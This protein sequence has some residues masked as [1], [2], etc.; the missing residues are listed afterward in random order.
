MPN[1]VLVSLADLE[2]AMT[3]KK[4]RQLLGIAGDAS[5]PADRVQM[6]LDNGHGFVFGEIQRAVKK[7]SVFALWL[8][9]WTPED[10][11]EIRRLVIGA[12]IYYLHYLG[13]MGEEVP[14]SVSAER[15]EIKD[16]CQRIGDHLATVAAESGPESSTQHDF[17]YGPGCGRHDTG[18]PRGR[19]QGIYN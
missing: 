14:D 6:I 11:A 9:Q 2:T 3:A 15:D 10:R 12:C 1:P 16:R 8:T 17:I 4:V 19:W 7:S 18:S 13:Q 5:I